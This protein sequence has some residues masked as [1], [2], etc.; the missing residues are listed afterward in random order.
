MTLDDCADYLLFKLTEDDRPLSLLKLQK[1]SYYVQAWHLAHHRA[2]MFEGRFE[3]WIHGPVN[4]ALK[5]RF[6]SEHSL[7]GTVTA[8]S[9]RREF[10]PRRLD[11]EDLAFVDSVLEAYGGFTGGQLE[12]LTRRELPWQKARGSREP[13]ER[14]E[15]L[16]D[17]QTMGDFYRERL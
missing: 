11:P 16:I 6:W 4:R 14:C 1:L 12:E 17:E 8:K 7:Y 3:A 13:T 2:P 9:I 15:T 10:D 5:D